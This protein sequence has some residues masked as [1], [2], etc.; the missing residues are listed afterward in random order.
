MVVQRFTWSIGQALLVDQ[1]PAQS[2]GSVSTYGPLQLRSVMTIMVA[3]W[4]LVG[5]AGCWIVR[6]EPSESNPAHAFSISLSGEFAVNADHARPD[7]AMSACPKAFAMAVLP[8]SVTALVALVAAI[9]VTT[10][11]GSAA[12]CAAPT[13]Q[14]PPR[15]VLIALTGQD[16]LT[17]FCL[18]RR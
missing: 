17:R 5:V 6:S 9:V 14:S 10:I 8:P 15:G 7:C 16:V 3:V 1:P 12:H 2:R 18:A 13:R 4:V 11:V